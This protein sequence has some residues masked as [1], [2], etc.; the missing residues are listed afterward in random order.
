MPA[1]RRVAL[2]L[3]LAYHVISQ[4]G[5]VTVME[6]PHLFSRSQISNGFNLVPAAVIKE[7]RREGK[8]AI[9]DHIRENSL[10]VAIHH[11]LCNM[12]LQSF[13]NHLPGYRGKAVN[14]DGLVLIMVMLLR[15]ALNGLNL[16]PSIIRNL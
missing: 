14:V 7:N 16:P 10:I 12:L 9:A 8:T 11:F 15:P 5:R 3:H 1:G 4:N 6:T 13:P 2:A